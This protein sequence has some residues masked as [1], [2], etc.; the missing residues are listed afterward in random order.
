MKPEE[1]HG[2]EEVAQLIHN[3]QIISMQ[4][5][6]WRDKAKSAKGD[7]IIDG[8]Y[9]ALSSKTA[10][11]G[12][13][14]WFKLKGFEKNYANYRYIEFWRP[15]HLSNLVSAI[16][17][18]LCGL[19][20]EMLQLTKNNLDKI[21]GY[22]NRELAPWMCLSC[23]GGLCSCRLPLPVGSYA[24]SGVSLQRTG[25]VSI[26]GRKIATEVIAELANGIHALLEG[27]LTSNFVRFAKKVRGSTGSVAGF[28]SAYQGV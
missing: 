11:H 17:D 10:R 28:H 4:A 3:N 15:K 2:P 7:A 14:F 8:K 5:I 22:V 26:S 18:P 1:V 12:A 27:Y 25:A 24:M 21:S 16:D 6:A 19:F 23:R 13:Y 20:L 9:Y